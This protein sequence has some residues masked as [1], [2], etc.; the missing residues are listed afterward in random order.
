MART[1]SRWPARRGGREPSASASARSSRGSR[2]TTVKPSNTS[3]PGRTI[4]EATRQAETAYLLSTTFSPLS[5]GFCPLDSV[6]RLLRLIDVRADDRA[7]LLGQM[8]G[9]G[10][11]RF[12][13]GGRQR[14]GA[15]S[16]T[17]PGQV[18]RRF[19]SMTWRLPATE[20]GT[21]GRPAWM[22]SRTLPPLNRPTVPSALRVPSGK[23]IS[24]SP[25]DTRPF[26]RFR[27]PSG[28]GL[29]RSTSRCPVRLRCHPRNGNRPSEAFAMMRS[30]TGRSRR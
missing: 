23:T 11:A 14:V 19:F 12:E 3:T 16:R 2:S 9:A 7:D 4:G 25:F 6:F 20:I 27:M 22:A 26:Q 28:S 24:D 30:S 13:A 8:A 1:A 18:I 21:I 5:S 10:R 15:T 17:W 29:F